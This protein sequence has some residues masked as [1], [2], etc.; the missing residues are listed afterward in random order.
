MI[1]DYNDTLL[2]DRKQAAFIA[3]NDP[4]ATRDHTGNASGDGLPS[5]ICMYQ[6]STCPTLP[7]LS[8]L[9]SELR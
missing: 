8:F 1:T 4:S 7:I 6:S 3:S 9:T 2:S 5:W